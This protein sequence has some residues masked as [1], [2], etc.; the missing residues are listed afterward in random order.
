MPRTRTTV[1]SLIAVGT[2][3]GA[4]GVATADDPHPG[5]SGTPTGDGAPGLCK[6]APKIDH[7]IDRIL[8]RLHADASRRGSIARL[9]QRVAAAKSAGHTEI[10]TYLNDRLTFRR[11]LVPTLEARQKDLAD[12]QKWC[13]THDNGADN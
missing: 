5:P 13:K 1:I 6:R 8:D 12:V 9:E 4:A 2:L 11:S 3:L 10:E 7:R